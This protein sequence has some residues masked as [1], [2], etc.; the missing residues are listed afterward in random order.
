MAYGFLMFEIVINTHSL[1]SLD[2]N[3]SLRL[4][5]HPLSLDRMLQPLI[6]THYHLRSY[7]PVLRIS[8][9]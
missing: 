2:R 1:V 9:Q 4:L 3:V 8:F 7:L 5:F 6:Y